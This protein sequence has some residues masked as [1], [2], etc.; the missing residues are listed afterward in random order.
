MIKALQ[1]LKKWSKKVENVKDSNLIFMKFEKSF[2][3]KDEENNLEILKNF[4]KEIQQIY[5]SSS[6][7]TSSIKKITIKFILNQLI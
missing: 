2:F 5:Q 3:Q 6:Q 7:D 1:K 4:D